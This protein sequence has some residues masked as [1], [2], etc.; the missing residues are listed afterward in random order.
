MITNDIKH[1]CELPTEFGNFRMYDTGNEKVNLISYGDIQSLNNPVL[2]RVHSSCIASE[3]FRALDCDCADQLSESMRLIS[4][5][6]N[7]III[8]LHQEGRGQGLS[9]K[10]KAVHLMQR[11]NID[12]VEAFDSMNLENDVREY[13]LA[14]QILRNLN[15]DK[16][17]LITNNPHKIKYF[18]VNGTIVQEEIH[19]SSIVREENREYLQSKINK[20]NH[21]IQLN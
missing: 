16:V 3:V 9:N 2:L 1:W 12:T 14:V 8:Y 17:R 18:E 21:Q 5:Q 19:L 10:I 11:K 15:I 7:G 20:L 4:K 13:H 6:K